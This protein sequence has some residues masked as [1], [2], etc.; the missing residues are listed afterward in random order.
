M[1]VDDLGKA[2]QTIRIETV[3]VHA[4]VVRVTR[5]VVELVRVDAGCLV[6]DDVIEKARHQCILTRPRS[7]AGDK[8]R[9]LPD[10]RP[11]V[12]QIVRIDEMLQQHT[13]PLF[14][15]HL[16]QLTKSRVPIHLRE[17]NMIEQMRI[18]S[19][20]KVVAQTRNLDNAE[21]VVEMT[22]VVEGCGGEGVSRVSVK[23]AHERG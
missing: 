21:R 19:V 2:H 11:L 13:G 4:N 14:M 17:E 6:R 16:R 1:R 7:V 9:D 15:M 23:T 3:S 12:V 22:R 8:T 5:E 18:W 20:T 10:R